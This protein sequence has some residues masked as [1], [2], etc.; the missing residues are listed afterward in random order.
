MWILLWKLSISI[1][2]TVQ[3][4]FWHWNWRFQAMS[5]SNICSGVLCLLS[6]VS[7]YSYDAVIKQ[8]F[9]SFYLQP[10]WLMKTLGSFQPPQVRLFITLWDVFS[11]GSCINVEELF[12]TKIMTLSSQVLVKSAFT[13]WLEEDFIWGV[14]IF[15]GLLE[16]TAQP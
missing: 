8:N 10:V 4:K 6:L 1:L 3:T 7:A 16:D 13:T 11:K 12:M 2:T 14:K 9:Y 15:L 5:H